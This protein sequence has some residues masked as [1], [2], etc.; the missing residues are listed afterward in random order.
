MSN[1]TAKIDLV[2][3]LL[4]IFSQ[5]KFACD[6]RN[7]RPNAGLTNSEQGGNKLSPYLIPNLANFDTVLSDRAS[8]YGQSNRPNIYRDTLIH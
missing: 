5:M 6:L 8:F 4:P 3:R 2:V 1:M 7:V